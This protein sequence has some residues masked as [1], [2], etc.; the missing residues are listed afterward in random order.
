MWWP[1]HHHHVSLC[2]MQRGRT[3]QAEEESG[4][5]RACWSRGWPDCED[6]CRKK[7][8]FHHVQGRWSVCT[9][10][11]GALLSWRGCG[12]VLW[13]RWELQTAHSVVCVSQ[14]TMAILVGLL[15]MLPS[16][17]CFRCGENK[18]SSRCLQVRNRI[19]KHIPLCFY[20]HVKLLV[21]IVSAK[22]TVL[23]FTRGNPVFWAKGNPKGDN[24]FHWELLDIY[25]RKAQRCYRHMHKVCVAA[26][27]I[28]VRHSNLLSLEKRMAR[29]TAL[30][31][32]DRRIVRR[33]KMDHMWNETSQ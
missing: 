9:V 21:G 25:L 14:G 31:S 28:I 8:N 20:L 33:K 19:T 7:G 27:F 5:P 2:C 23:L 6:A 4:D 10:S 17:F 12:W 11:I 15:N 18:A 22:G 16:S 30:W 1:R 29:W 13:E 3:S 32:Q 26:L 24:T